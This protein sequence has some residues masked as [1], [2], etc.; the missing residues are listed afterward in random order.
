MENSYR[1]IKNR[2]KFLRLLAASPL[3]ALPRPSHILLQE[4]LASGNPGTKDAFA[5][6]ESLEQGDALIS[7]PEQAFDVMDFEPVARKTLPSAH[8]GFLATGVDDDATV[9]ANREGFTKLQ[10]RS[11]RLV[12]VSNIDMSVRLFGTSWD[13]PIVLSPVGDQKAFHPEGEVA[14]AKA[15][16]TKGDLQILSTVTSYSVEDVTAARGAPIWFQLY[17]NNVWDIV[18]AVIKRAEAAACP[19]LVLTVDLKE[20]SNRET[21][22]R[23]ERADSRQCSVCHTNGFKGFGRVAARPMFAGLDVSKATNLI[24]PALNWDYVKRLKD[25]TTM[26]LVLKGIV[27]REDAQLAVEHGVD[28]IIVSN[29]GGRAEETLRSSIESLPEVLEGAAGKIPVIVDGGIRRGTDAFKALALG[30]TAVGIGRPYIW[31]LAAF[32]QPGV[33]AVL[34]ILQ[35][36]LQTI[37]RQAGTT[38]IDKITS[39]Y[40]AK[41]T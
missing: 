31:G 7:S 13:S 28:G 24:S 6:F 3:L 30:A 10:I 11:R 29:H 27:T 39:T 33:E 22:F 1:Q 8:F 17:V 15:A 16:R 18:R 23:A 20:G 2:R 34:T 36:E 14:A 38:S 37:M 32:G 21:L 19:V 41:K 5:L 4:L 9:R 12:D 35:R 26:K 25:T 40:L